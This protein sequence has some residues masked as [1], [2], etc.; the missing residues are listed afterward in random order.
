MV[1]LVS[2]FR[3]HLLNTLTKKMS[4]EVYSQLAVAHKEAKSIKSVLCQAYLINICES[5]PLKAHSL[6][7]GFFKEGLLNPSTPF[8][9]CN[10][11][12]KAYDQE[13]KN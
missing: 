10:C 6:D 4:K 7:I 1:S 8:C 9:F 2:K 3:A 12:Y 13:Q 5:T 11:K